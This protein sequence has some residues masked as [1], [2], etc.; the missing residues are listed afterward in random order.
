M[1]I[2]SA[3][4]SSMAFIGDSSRLHQLLKVTATTHYLKTK[5]PFH[6][7]LSLLLIYEQ[8]HRQHHLY[9]YLGRHQLARGAGTHGR[10]GR[11]HPENTLERLRYPTAQKSSF[12]NATRKISQSF[13]LLARIS[14][15]H[16]YSERAAVALSAWKKI[17]RPSLKTARR[18]I[19]HL[20][21]RPNNLQNK[22]EA[23]Q[24]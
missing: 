14:V 20:N 6:T 5:D 1:I 9:V 19:R 15:P 18:I 12:L 22:K 17:L 2:K 10:L 23:T 8:C 7:C 16:R 3:T 13:T 11:A 24:I 21:G 4:D